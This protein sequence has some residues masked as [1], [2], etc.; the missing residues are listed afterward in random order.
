MS[1]L[2]CVITQSGTVNVHERFGAFVGILRPGF[3]C[4]V[5]CID[6][7]SENI[8]MRLQ[9]M[10]ITCEAKTKDNV[11]CT[12]KVAIQYQVK[13]DDEAI[14]AAAYRLTNARGQIESYVFDVVRA[15]VP[16]IDLDDV[17][18][19][20]DELSNSIKQQLSSAMGSFGYEIL[21]T[22]ITD[23]DPDAQVRSPC[24]SSHWHPLSHP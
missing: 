21:A 14:K 5:P 1:C 18:L 22:P 16:T 23:I 6:G 2:P 15:S 11:F 19:M 10:E 9:Q 7:V 17:F 20:K 4:L 24:P 12:I 3:S 13:T 8:T